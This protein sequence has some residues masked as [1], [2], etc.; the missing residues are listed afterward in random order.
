MRRKKEKEGR[1]LEL[2]TT[3]KKKEKNA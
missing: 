2:S 1:S 3:E